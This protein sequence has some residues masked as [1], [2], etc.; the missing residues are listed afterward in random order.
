MMDKLDFKAAQERL[1]LL[2]DMQPQASS[3]FLQMCEYLDGDIT[4]DTTRIHGG[5][6]R[7]HRVG[8]DTFTITEDELDYND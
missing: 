6:I 8:I 7:I 3:M 5:T 1:F 4:L 2:T